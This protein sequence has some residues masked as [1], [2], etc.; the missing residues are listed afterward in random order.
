M[1]EEELLCYGSR[2][3]DIGDG[4]HF[5]VREG[6]FFYLQAWIDWDSLPD[7][8]SPLDPELMSFAGELYEIVHSRFQPL[9]K[10]IVSHRD[11]WVTQ[12]S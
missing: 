4:P 9:S 1:V 2:L 7:R 12:L 10:Y 3:S 5:L 6:P 8:Q 11:R